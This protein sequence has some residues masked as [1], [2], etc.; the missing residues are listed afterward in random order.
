MRIT[1]EPFKISWMYFHQLPEVI[2]IER[3]SHLHPWTEEEFRRF[4]QQQGCIFRVALVHGEVAGFMVY[5][6]HDHKIELVNLAVAPKWRLSG[7]ASAMA[8]HLK[9]KLSPTRSKIVTVV[10][11][12]NLPAQLFLKKQGFRGEATL[13][14]Y[15]D[16][17]SLSGIVFYYYIR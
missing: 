2:A 14:E 10:R 9:R 1:S 3:A 13:H 12:T 7:I 6:L 16:Q 11:E 17:G 15:F 4:A 8:G 5:L